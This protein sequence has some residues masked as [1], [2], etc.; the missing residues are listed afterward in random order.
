VDTGLDGPTGISGFA[1]GFGEKAGGAGI[2]RA[3]ELWHGT[4]DAVQG[5]ERSLNGGRYFDNKLGTRGIY[6]GNYSRRRSRRNRCPCEAAWKAVEGN[7]A[8]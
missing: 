3:P 4:A 6:G 7:Y 1:G 5:L 2:L 8:P